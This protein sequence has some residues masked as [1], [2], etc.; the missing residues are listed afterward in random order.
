MHLG[1]GKKKIPDNHEYAPKNTGPA[2]SV[3]SNEKE[4][5]NALDNVSK[6]RKRPKKK[7]LKRKV[8]IYIK[9]KVLSVLRP[10][11]RPK[12]L[13]DAIWPKNAGAFV[14]ITNIAILGL[15][16][17][18]LYIKTAKADTSSFNPRYS[19]ILGKI[20]NDNLSY[21]W[22]EPKYPEVL[23]LPDDMLESFARRRKPTF[24]KFDIDLLFSKMARDNDYT[25]TLY[26]DF[27]YASK[28][29]K[30]C[31]ISKDDNEDLNLAKTCRNKILVCLGK[32]DVS[33]VDQSDLKKCMDKNKECEAMKKLDQGAAVSIEYCEKLYGRKL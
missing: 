21:F 10:I 9:R 5:L 12:N 4:I 19:E 33:N 15:L 27:E 3:A 22:D 1:I 28:N 8:F 30:K 17:M 23:Q 25:Y 7:S 31:V 29:F 18:A 26:V 14:T 24:S 2:N 6:S 32:K 13:R 11:D 20:K 16:L